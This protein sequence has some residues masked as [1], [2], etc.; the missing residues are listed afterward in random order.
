M[1][2]T[3]ELAKLNGVAIGAHPSLPDLQGFGRRE[4]AIEPVSLFKYSCGILF[5]ISCHQEELKA[6]FIYQVGAL[7]GFLKLHGLPLNHVRL[8]Y[9][10]KA[11]SSPT[12]DQ[13]TWRG[14]RANSSFARACASPRSSCQGIQQESRPTDRSCGFSGNGPSNGC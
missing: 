13:A 8:R 12:I 6:C 11:L 14:I 10:V 3:V 4:M 9:P 5:S 1:N 2:K 7:S